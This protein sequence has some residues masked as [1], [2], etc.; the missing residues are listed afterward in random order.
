MDTTGGTGLIIYS[1]KTGNTRTLA[2]GVVQGLGMRVK[3]A[4]IEENLDALSF[5][6]VIIGFWVDRGDLD[7]KARSYVETLSGCKV[8]LIGTLGAYP[9]SPHAK[10]VENHVRDVISARNKYLGCFL[11]QGRIDPALTRKF[12]QLPP[13]HPHAMNEERRKR[14]TEAA[15][16]P[17]DAD[18]AAATAAC[19]EMIKAAR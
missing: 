3:L 18:I 10:D 13:D 17:N 7:A 15:F 8:G 14:H 6:W 1:S 16:H 2:R 19:A 9:D 11:C 5:S 4:A 12:E